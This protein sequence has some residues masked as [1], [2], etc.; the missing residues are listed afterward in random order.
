VFGRED[1]VPPANQ[2]GRSRCR[3]AEFRAELHSDEWGYAFLRALSENL[4]GL[5]VVQRRLKEGSRVYPRVEP[6]RECRKL[7]D[8]AAELRVHLAIALAAPT[9]VS[10]ASATEQK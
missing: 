7:W 5:I 8:Q 4:S 1:V 10:P 3:V 2:D 6:P 9:R